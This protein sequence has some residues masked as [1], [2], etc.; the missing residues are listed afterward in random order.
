MEIHP[1]TMSLAEMRT[2][3]ETGGAIT[4]PHKAWEAIDAAAAPRISGEF[5]HEVA[6]L[7]GDQVEERFPDQLLGSKADQGFDRA[8]RERDD[9]EGIQFDQEFAPAK[10]EGDESIPFPAGPFA[11]VR[12]FRRDGDDN[13]HGP[14]IRSLM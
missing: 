8:G 12:I 13:G 4:L 10:G 2:L 14:P 1:G 3:F 7:F 11:R 5:L 6:I 9:P